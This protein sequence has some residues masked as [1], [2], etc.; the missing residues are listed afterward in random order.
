ML[1]FEKIVI[2]FSL[3]LLASCGKY[4]HADFFTSAV[5]ELPETEEIVSIKTSMPFHLRGLMRYSADVTIRYREKEGG[6]VKTVTWYYANPDDKCW[7]LFA[8]K[9]YSEISN[10]EYVPISIEKRRL[11]EMNKAC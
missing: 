7:Y 3:L 4:S 1:F 9:P 6:E 5:E 2:A 8:K 11:R 10:D